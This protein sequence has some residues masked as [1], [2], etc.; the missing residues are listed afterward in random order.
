MITITA[1]DTDL[2]DRQYRSST[3]RNTDHIEHWLRIYQA[4]RLYRRGILFSTFVVAPGEILQGC[5]TLDALMRDP[6]GGTEFASLLPRQ[7]A[8][9]ARLDANAARLDRQPA[10]CSGYRN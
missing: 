3:D 2:L 6:T 5:Q 4:N 1:S 10:G 8:V 9:Q 7:A